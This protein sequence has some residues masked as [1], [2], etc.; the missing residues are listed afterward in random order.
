MKFEIWA[1]IEVANL[2]FG[3]YIDRAIRDGVNENGLLSHKLSYLRINKEIIKISNCSLE[4]SQAT[5]AVL[6]RGAREG[7]GLKPDWLPCHSAQ[8]LLHFQ[9]CMLPDEQCRCI[10]ILQDDLDTVSIESPNV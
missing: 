5:N 7:L 10:H 3:L 4:E 8:S 9:P 1:D 2:C 6:L